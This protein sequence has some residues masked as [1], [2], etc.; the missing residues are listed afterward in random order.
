MHKVNRAEQSSARASE[1]SL[2]SI[3]ISIR[4]L[5]LLPVPMPMLMPPM[6]LMRLRRPLLHLLPKSQELE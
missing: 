1:Y 3:N 4:L 5:L 6:L 2:A